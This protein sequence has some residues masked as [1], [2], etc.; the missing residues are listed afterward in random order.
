MNRIMISGLLAAVLVVAVVA[1]IMPLERV[2]TIHPR[3]F[4]GASIAADSITSAQI[5]TDAVGAD[6]L[7]ANAVTAAGGEL[8][9]DSVTS[10][11]IAPNTIVAGDIFADT[12]TPTEL[13]DTLTLDAATS[14]VTSGTNLITIGDT[15]ATSFRR[16]IITQITVDL[17]AVGAN[18]ESCITSGA[19]TGIATTD[20]AVATPNFDLVDG[21]AV[22]RA[23]V[24][25]ADT[26]QVCVMETAG[27]VGPTNPDA[28]GG[29]WNVIVLDL[30]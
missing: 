22:S 12:I 5:A 24:S 19:V 14:I 1:A 23:R 15:G 26:I 16:L 2:S 3:T 9:A 7:A 29:S 13:A 11:K 30:T 28:T 17:P 27:L 20:I 21:F 8:A 18:A 6:E 4:T 10:A 25:A